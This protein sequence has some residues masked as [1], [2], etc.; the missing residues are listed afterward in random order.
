MWYAIIGVVVALFII[1]VLWS[2]RRNRQLS[3]EIGRYEIHT[4]PEGDV[5]L[6]SDL[7]PQDRV[8]LASH[9]VGA[10]L[11]YL[12]GST[13]FE[14]LVDEVRQALTTPS[15]KVLSAA[16]EGA[17]RSG[18]TLTYAGVGLSGSIGGDPV[19]KA[20]ATR[21]EAVGIIRVVLEDPATAEQAQAI[22]PVIVE[23][24]VDPRLVDLGQVNGRIRKHFP[25]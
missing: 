7:A 9:I 1:A 24:E 23:Q 11:F 8:R 12:R 19:A 22:L 3:R 10:R 17:H 5:Y 20:R 15:V 21:N 2:V 18:G 14:E 16:P 25:S 6:D 13:G 4:T